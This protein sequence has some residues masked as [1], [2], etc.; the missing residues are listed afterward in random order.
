[1]K[2]VIF[3]DIDGVMNR[4]GTFEEG[5]TTT[6]W[7]GYIGMD[8]ELVALF[9]YIVKRIDA[10]VVLSSTWRMDPNWQE[11]MRK[12]GFDFEFLD[13]TPR[14]PGKRR[15]EEIYAWLKQNRDI[16]RYA[17]IDDD[18]DMLVL[19][20]PHFFHTDYRLGLTKEMATEIIRYLSTGVR[21]SIP[22]K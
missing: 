22:I 9:N 16:K 20:K 18:S 5:R 15:G 3:L 10:Y 17:I 7:E 6:K 2:P 8:P 12:N 19:Q 11:T 4:L 21:Y 14:H 13:K 1:M